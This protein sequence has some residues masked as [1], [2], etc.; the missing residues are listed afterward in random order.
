MPRCETTDF[1]D[2]DIFQIG[3]LLSTRSVRAAERFIRDLDK[4]FQRLA[5]FPDLGT[6]RDDLKERSEERRVGKECRL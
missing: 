6:A 3:C 2:E 4:T 1:A 5:Q